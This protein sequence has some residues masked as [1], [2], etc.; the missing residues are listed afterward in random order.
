MGTNNALYWYIPTGDTDCLKL[1]Y[2]ISTKDN[3]LTVTN[4]FGMFTV[5]AKCTNFLWQMWLQ[6]YS[7]LQMFYSFSYS[8]I[9]QNKLTPYSLQYL[10]TRRFYHLQ[11]NSL[12]DDN[13]TQCSVRCYI[14]DCFWN[15]ALLQNTEWVISRTNNL[16]MQLQFEA[17]FT[18]KLR[19]DFCYRIFIVIKFILFSFLF[20][21]SN[22]KCKRF[23]FVWKTFKILCSSM[24][25]F[26]F[27]KILLGNHGRNRNHNS[28]NNNESF[29]LLFKFDAV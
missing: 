28:N 1:A 4:T 12:C 23:S 19:L 15:W 20:E 24:F 26:T 18:W 13:I 11:R 29:S 3:V 5:L 6:L 16:I 27:E 8:L 10:L 22:L 25:F 2:L 21:S 17:T 7:V 9:V 14:L